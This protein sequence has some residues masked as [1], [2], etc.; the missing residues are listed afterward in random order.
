MA[1][2]VVVPNERPPAASCCKDEI[3][4]RYD[5]SLSRAPT[6]EKDT[7]VIR[8]G[9]CDDDLDL[10][11]GPGGVDRRVARIGSSVKLKPAPRNNETL[12]VSVNLD[13][14]R[15]SHGWNDNA[16]AHLDKTRILG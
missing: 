11:A 12:K 6:R 4:L 2:T 9:D 5:S 14:V 13:V 7:I 15:Q 16:H 1:K 8:R 10:L 3:A